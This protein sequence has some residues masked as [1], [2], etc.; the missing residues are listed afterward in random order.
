MSSN[1]APRMCSD[2]CSFVTYARFAGRRKHQARQASHPGSLGGFC[3]TRKCSAVPA[4]ATNCESRGTAHRPS[5][6]NAP[7]R[8]PAPRRRK[9][10]HP[11]RPTKTSNR[12]RPRGFVNRNDLEDHSPISLLAFALRR[13]GIANLSTHSA[14]LHANTRSTFHEARGRSTELAQSAVSPLRSILAVNLARFWRS[15][16][17]RQHKQ[18]LQLH[19]HSAIIVLWASCVN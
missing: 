17:S 2:S 13:T 12:R 16:P 14:D 15:S 3:T 9:A 6:K 11:T 7:W 5:R 10:V 18:I 1:L 8:R 19:D 4:R